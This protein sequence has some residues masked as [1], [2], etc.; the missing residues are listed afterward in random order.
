MNV[1]FSLDSYETNGGFYTMTNGVYHTKYSGLY[2][3]PKP[4]NVCYTV[5]GVKKNLERKYYAISYSNHLNAG[6]ATITLK[7]INGYT[8]SVSKT[9]KIDPIPITAYPITVGNISD[10]TYNGVYQ[11]PSVSVKYSGSSSS[12][13]QPHVINMKKG[14][15]YVPVFSNN[16]NT[17]TATVTIKGKGNLT[18][19]VTRTFKIKPK[20]IS[21]YSASLAFLSKTY[22]G[23]VITPDVTVKDP[24]G[25][26][27]FSGN[28]YNTYSNCTNAGTAKVTVT[29]VGNYC[30]TITRTYQI[31]PK[32]IQTGYVV[33]LSF[34]SKPYTGK[35]VKPTVTVKTTSGGYFPSTN[36][37]VS[38]VNN[39]NRGLAQVKIT[40]KGNYTGT[41]L[42]SFRIT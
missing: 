23:S 34:S 37:T 22:T 41:I 35:P 38:Y 14:T 30:G 16:K 27:L 3:E 28:Y 13:E 21:G 11:Y 36:Y 31:R 26:V 25:N 1:T 6:T 33:Y 40:G 32:S 15:D 39:I 7:G 24:N 20:S 2:K 18:G 17:G 29:G 9:F 19:S 5:G 4:S 8:G 10:V 12:K 42:K